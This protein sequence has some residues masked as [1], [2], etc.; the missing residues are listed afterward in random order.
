MISRKLILFN[1]GCP[2]NLLSI[3][4]KL[5]NAEPDFDFTSSFFLRCLYE[6]ESGDPESPD[7]GFLK[8]PLLMRVSYA[9]SALCVIELKL[10]AA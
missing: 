7:I 4:A 5:R 1:L 3:R 10:R 8:G 2:N 9:S 6:G